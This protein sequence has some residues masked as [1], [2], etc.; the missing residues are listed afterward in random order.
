M[1]FFLATALIIAGFGSNDSRAAYL[2][3]KGIYG[4]DNRRLVSEIDP[5]SEKEQIAE[6]HVVFAQIPKWRIT[7]EDGDSISIQTKSLASGMNFCPD[8]KFSDLPITSSCS[9]FLVGPDLI[10]TAGHCVKDKY[11]CQKNFWVL[12]YND[13]SGFV[14]TS[15]SVNF[16]KSN[17]FSCSQIISSAENQKLDYALIKLDRKVDRSP[18]KIRRSGKIDNK[19]SLLVIGHPMGLPKILT[20]EAIIRDNSLEF[21][22]KTNAD[23]FSGNS[24][25]PVINPK[26]QLVEGIL[27]KGDEDFEMDIETGCN[28][29]FHCFANECKGETVQR[30]TT[31]PLKLIPKI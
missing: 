25:S 5:E 24:G 10:L 31:L 4:D 7:S 19:D 27:I 9:A 6:A 11:E 12:D 30:I 13:A 21:T 17:V 15:G 20:N 28:R 23:T 1:K 3:D 8:E 18:L 22:F 2:F 16:S 26:T 14:G 29:S